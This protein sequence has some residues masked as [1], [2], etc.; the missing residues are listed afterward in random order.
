MGPENVWVAAMWLL[1]CVAFVTGEIDIVEEMI[2]G[3]EFSSF[4]SLFRCIDLSF[5]LI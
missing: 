4:M 1:S 5:S 3:T 2:T